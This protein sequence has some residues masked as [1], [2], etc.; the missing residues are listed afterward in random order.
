MSI[1]SD[2]LVCRRCQRPVGASAAQYEV[3]EHMHYVCF[4]YEFEHDPFDPDEECNAGGCPSG[5][6]KDDREHLA[7]TLRSLARDAA[8][9]ANW[10]NNTLSGYL[11]A[12]AAWL[13]DADG[14]YLNLNRV[15]PSNHWETMNDAL[16]AATVYE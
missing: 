16:R 11:D 7:Q 5:A 3:F 6:L 13:A 15:R 2:Q 8:A 12:L 9:G 1:P 4:H 14:Y 10:E